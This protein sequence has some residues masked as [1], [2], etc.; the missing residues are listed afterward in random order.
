MVL[1]SASTADRNCQNFTR[2]MSSR[3]H[4]SKSTLLD[5]GPNA[6]DVRVPYTRSVPAVHNAFRYADKQDVICT[7]ADCP[8]FYR[9]TARQKEVTAAVTQLDRFHQETNW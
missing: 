3:R 4:H 2:N 6:S 9:R 5:Y 7:S 1:L 8:I